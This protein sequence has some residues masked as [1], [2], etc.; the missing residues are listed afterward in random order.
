MFNTLILMLTL[1]FLHVTE[2]R[3]HA[4]F[5]PD[6]SSFALFQNDD[7][8]RTVWNLGGEVGIVDFIPN[9]GLK[10]RGAK[11]KYESGTDAWEYTPISLCT[12]FNLLPFIDLKWL[13]LSAETGMGIYWWKGQY[14]ERDIGF[15]GGATLQIRPINIFALEVL[16]RYNYM[17]TSNIYKYGFLDKDDKIWENGFGLRVLLP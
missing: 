10:L 13:R 11:I 3:I 1:N 14:N 17:G 9:V 12:S 5:G 8:A 7:E 15:V 2:N 16:T 4:S 6:Y